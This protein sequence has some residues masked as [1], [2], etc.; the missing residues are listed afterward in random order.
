MPVM[1]DGVVIHVDVAGPTDGAA[2][3]F[4]HGLTCSGRDFDWLPNEVTEGRRIIRVDLRGHGRSSHAPRTYT[5]ANYA[6]DVAAVIGERVGSPAVIVGHSLGAMVAW[7]L[8]Q[9]RPDVVKAAFLEDPP[10]YLNDPAEFDASRFPEFFR[11]LRALVV[12]MHQEGLSAEQFGERVRDWPIGP[13]TPIT[14]KDVNTDD[15]LAS[16]G[17]GLHSMDIGVLDGVTWADIDTSARVLVPV[18]VLAAD[19]DFDAAFLSRWRER[20]ARTHPDVEVTRVAGAG[21]A[22]HGERRHRA[23]YLEHLRRFLD[24]HA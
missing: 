10:L 22:I 19:D 23:T 12:A 5:T 21:H 14:L 2:V 20:L 24:E 16:W 1:G 15:N 11:E 6:N 3:V 9:Q 18:F 4:V 7:R 17:Y 13:D 8:A